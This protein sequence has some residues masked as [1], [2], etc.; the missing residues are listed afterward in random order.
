MPLTA[1]SLDG[2]VNSAALFSLTAL[3]VAFVAAAV[4]LFC[5]VLSFCQQL[6]SLQAQRTISYT[7]EKAGSLGSGT[8]ALRMS[9]TWWC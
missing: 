2:I 3:I 5:S 8:A 6:G 7:L 9:S 4:L 1:D